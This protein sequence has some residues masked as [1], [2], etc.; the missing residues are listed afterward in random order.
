MQAVDMMRVH[1]E[2]LL[3]AELCVEMPARLHVPK[4][5]LM[6]ISRC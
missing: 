5:K 4:A 6:E 1:R 3:A 2:R